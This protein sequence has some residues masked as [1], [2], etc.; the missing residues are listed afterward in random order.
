MG[1]CR[2]IVSKQMPMKSCAYC[3]RENEDDATHCCECGTA[4]FAL[5]TQHPESPQEPNRPALSNKTIRLFVIAAFG[6]L[7]TEAVVQ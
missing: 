4:E 6:L 3:S 7:V 2:Q 1:K 5:P